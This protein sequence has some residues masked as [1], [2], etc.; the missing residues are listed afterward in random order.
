MSP[1]FLKDR[2]IPVGSRILTKGGRGDLGPDRCVGLGGCVTQQY[3]VGRVCGEL[4]P[5]RATCGESDP[6]AGGDRG[7]LGP[8]RCVGLLGCVTQHYVM[9]NL[10]VGSQVLTMI[11]VGSWILTKGGC[12]GT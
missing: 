4:G 7:D 11:P 8:D 1:F 12:V 5:G 2:G 3:V 9:G 10:C 6:D